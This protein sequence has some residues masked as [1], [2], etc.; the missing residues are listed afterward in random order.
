M[1]IVLLLSSALFSVG[2]ASKGTQVVLLPDHNN[3]VGRVELTNAHGTTA[4]DQAGYSV[5]LNQN[6]AP[7]PQARL[8]K[9]EIQSRFA[10]VLE[11]EP[12]PPAKFILYFETGT[13]VLTTKSQALMPKVINEIK[14]RGSMDISVAG[15]S[16]RVGDEKSNIALSLKRAKSITDLLEREG[17]AAHH[18]HTSSHGEGNPLIPTKD[19][20]SEPRNRRVEVIVR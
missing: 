14:R 3:H 20:V 12:E 5:T 15:H 19:N 6:A 11:V 8:K 2:C 18:L 10:S 4:I 1:C 7:K 16:D 13:A 9:K 17:V